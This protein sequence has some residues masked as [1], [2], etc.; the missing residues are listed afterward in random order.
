M[1][2]RAVSAAIAISHFTAAGAAHAETILDVAGPLLA[3][4]HS[5]AAFK[6]RCDT[7]LS[8]IAER[9][10]ALAGRV[11][12]A[13]IDG[14]LALYDETLGLLNLAYGEFALY[15]QVMPGEDERDAASECQT[16]L[17]GIDAEISL[18]RAIYDRLASIDARKADPAAK[19]VLT[20]AVAAFERAGVALDDASRQRVKSLQEEIAA[21]GLAFEQ[22]I[23][24][25]VRTL[26]VRPEDLAGLPDD[27]IE[28]HPPGEDGE[29]EISTAYPDYYP[30]MTYAEKDD[31]R[32]D[33]DK[34]FGTRA[35]PINDEPLRH[36]LTQRQELAEL[37]G[38]PS[39]AALV[40]EGKMIDTPAKVEKLLADMKKAALPAGARDYGRML[41]ALKETDADATAVEQWQTYYLANKIRAR[42][43]DF[44]S[45]EARRYFAYDNVRDGMF[46]LTQD[47]FGVEI[48]PWDTPVWHEDVRAYEMVEDGDVIGRFY[49][50][51][52][53]RAGKFSHDNA[54]Q[55]KSGVAGVAP[56]VAALVMNLPKGGHDTGLMR[57]SDVAIFLHEYGHLLHALFGGTQKWLTQSG[58]AT[59]E[60]FIEA[61]S[62]MLENWVYDYDTL[63]TFAVDENGVVIPRDLVEKMNKSRNFNKARYD[64]FLMGLANI[65]LQLHLPP[66]PENLGAASRAW[67]DE[68]DLV[69]SPEWLEY[70]ASFGHLPSYSALVYSYLWSLVIAEDLF[71]RFEKEGLRNRE[72]AADYRRL[73]LAP[74]G[75]K[76]AAELARDFL[77]R[78]MN[79]K[80]YRRN[81]DRT[82]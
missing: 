24:D 55:I 10:D 14:D 77:G 70:Q 75:S 39:Y 34:L 21:T 57:P 42:D 46:R 61:P 71:T 2:F 19:K 49:F 59:E 31:V 33:I 43:Y 29:A 52:H 56:P 32:E 53:P 4:G 40:L 48:R 25:D 72:T 41:D 12:P 18:S 60:D 67:K 9:R 5:A 27:F 62:Q 68:F 58:I 6:E 64:L 37:L 65:S 76:P 69:A 63:A 81:L 82:D 13:S 45:Q 74:G 15:R 3:E 38:R 17:T 16:A 1:T 30:V 73:V 54:L 7:Y 22:N 23:D 51:S 28:N 50:D 79:F 11:G 80:A 47:L 44:D 8:A 66:T 78:K 35:F 26:K 36:M 20:K